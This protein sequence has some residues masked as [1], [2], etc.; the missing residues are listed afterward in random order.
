MDN[1]IL[2]R[3]VK[4]SDADG[5][6]ECRRLDGVMEN[7]IGLPSDRIKRSEDSI[8]HLDSNS[9]VFVAVTK[10]ED[11]NEIVVGWAGLFIDS[12]PRLRHC[13][14]IGLMVH[15]DYQQ[16]GI[17]TELMKTLI[18]LADNWLMLVRL[19]LEVFS[20]NEKAIRLYSKFGFEKEGTKRQSTIRNGRL[21]DCD[22][23]A[24]IKQFNI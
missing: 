14:G 13:A 8:E 19:E 3:P 1:K 15:T 23:M 17:G 11:D 20:D 21:E 7:T 16:A 9:H 6:N 12:S 4:K 10:N 2:I 18:N 5:L 22:I 24:R